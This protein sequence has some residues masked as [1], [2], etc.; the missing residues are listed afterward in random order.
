VVVLDVNVTQK[1]HI[2]VI[3]AVLR[4]WEREHPQLQYQ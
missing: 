4:Q 2:V 1:E 3:V